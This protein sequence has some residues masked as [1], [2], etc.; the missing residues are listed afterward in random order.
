MVSFSLGQ[1]YEQ[2]SLLRYFQRDILLRW[3]TCLQSRDAKIGLTR[4]DL[5]LHASTLVIDDQAA[6][7][8]TEHSVENTVAGLICL[9]LVDHVLLTVQSYGSIPHRHEHVVLGG[10]LSVLHFG[11]GAD[12]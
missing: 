10:G 6:I 9:Y 5:G 8:T 3:G 4:Q 12:L 2:C 7:L 11:D 1:L